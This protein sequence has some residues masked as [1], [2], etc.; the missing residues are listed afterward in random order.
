[1]SYI[2]TYFQEPNDAIPNASLGDINSIDFICFLSNYLLY[3]FIFE[4]I[5]AG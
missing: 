5:F 4:A 2:P 3:I 1:M